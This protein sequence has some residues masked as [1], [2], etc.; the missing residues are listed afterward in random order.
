MAFCPRGLLPELGNHTQAVSSNASCCQ[1]LGHVAVKYSA[2]PSVAVNYPPPRCISGFVR[3]SDQNFEGCRP[4]YV[5]DAKLFNGLH[6]NHHWWFLHP[7]IQDGA[8]KPEIVSFWH[9]C[10]FL[11]DIWVD[12]YVLLVGKLNA[13]IFIQ[14]SEFILMSH[15]KMAAEK[16]HNHTESNIVYMLT[17][18]TLRAKLKALPVC[19]RHLQR[20]ICSKF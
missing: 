18:W 3:P 15:F 2:N 19:G 4:T 17:Q 6:D 13:T 7:E 11:N 9:V 14:T 20:Q 5:F 8:C 16:H 10:L 1:F 12:Y